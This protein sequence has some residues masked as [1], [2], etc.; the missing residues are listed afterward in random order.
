[1]RLCSITQ[2]E[3][4]NKLRWPARIAATLASVLAL[5]GL[6]TAA[7]A[8]SSR[9][10]AASG[11]VLSVNVKAPETGHSGWQGDY[12]YDVPAGISGLFFH[13]SCSTGHAISGAF[14]LPSADP[15]EDT[16]NLVNNSPIQATKPQFSQW[17]WSF[18][19]SG[20]TAPSGSEIT[21][22]VYCS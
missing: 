12:T 6:G 22:D 10:P 9:T 8:A 18:T 3:S 16:I 20:G 14:R 4:R 17:G 5:A 19:W 11:R 1:M 7:H 15:S 21:F 13:Y 2:P